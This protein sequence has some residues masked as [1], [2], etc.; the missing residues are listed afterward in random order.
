MNLMER[1][2]DSTVITKNR[3]VWKRPDHIL[4]HCPHLLGFCYY[5]LPYTA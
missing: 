3:G 4:K 2:F 1:G 5:E